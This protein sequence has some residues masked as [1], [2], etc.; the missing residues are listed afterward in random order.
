MK[1][2][3]KLTNTTISADEF[4]RILEQA[5]STKWK[6]LKK[7]YGK[8]PVEIKTVISIL[9]IGFV[10]LVID[11]LQKNIWT[12]KPQAIRK[13][14]I[15]KFD[16]VEVDKQTVITASETWS[17]NHETLFK[18]LLQQGGSF[19]INGVKVEVFPVAKILN[20]KNEPEMTVPK[21]DPIGKILI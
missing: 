18:K 20:S 2:K 11:Y 16:N 19:K 9:L 17:P 10:A 7:F 3:I 21:T 12:I 15:V 13:G 14:V 8:I 6:N 5:L 1:N 4:L